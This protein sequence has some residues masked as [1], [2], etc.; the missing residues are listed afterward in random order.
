MSGAD[1]GQAV[2]AA[3]WACGAAVGFAVMFR[4]PPRLL[5]P[6]L[7]C[8]WCGHLARGIAIGS[9]LTIE[10]GTAVGATLVGFIAFAAARREGVTSL[11]FAVP[12]I[13]PMVP[14]VFAYRGMVGL[15]AVTRLD[16]G[17][18]LRAAVADG[19]VSSLRA[20]FIVGAIAVGISLPSIL[21][22]PLLRRDPE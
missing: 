22:R 19:A 2:I 12:A 21:L 13:I 17:P 5:L 11:V 14:G 3:L 8:T 15:L 9:G 7:A 4:L 6:C 10:G 20:A 1:W 18:E 16:D